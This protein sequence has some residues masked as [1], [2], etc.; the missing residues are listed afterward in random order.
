MK[1]ILIVTEAFGGGVRRHI[2]DLIS[3]INSK[4]EMYLA[5]NIHRSDELGLEGIEELKKLGVSVIYLKY[6]KRSFSIEDIYAISEIKKVVS[7]IKP[8]IIHLHS[9]KAGAIGRIAVGMTFK[10]K[11]VYTPHAYY[12]QNPNHDKVKNCCFAF[13]E[14]IL[15]RTLT[16][17]TVNVSDGEKRIAMAFEIDKED[18][19]KVIYNGIPKESKINSLKLSRLKN[20]LGIGRNEIVIGTTARMDHQKDPMT[21]LQIAERIIASNVNVKFVYI[22]DGLLMDEVRQCVDRNSD[23]KERVIL[24]GY[25]TNA[26]DYLKIFD[27]YLTTALY[28]GMPYSS[29]EALKSGLPIVATNVVGNNEITFEN[30]GSL[31]ELGDVDTAVRMINE[32]ICNKKMRSQ[33]GKSS[34]EIFLE[35]FEYNLMIDKYVSLYNEILE[36]A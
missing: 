31:F 1:K 7:S 14:R 15:S 20:E 11:V 32:M 5:V 19:F 25:V 6:L 13:V 16:A 10:S 2:V 34:E 22:G 35:K 12:F 18:K 36:R 23:M 21:F 3:G 30:N 4:F 29:I 27:V 33:K 24:T 17:C 9:S 28:E 26:E 8:D